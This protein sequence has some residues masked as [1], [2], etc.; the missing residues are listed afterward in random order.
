M[1]SPDNMSNVFSK[2]KLNGKTWRFGW[3]ILSFDEVSTLPFWQCD[4]RRIWSGRTA[5]R[6]SW[7]S[8]GG[9]LQMLLW[10]NSIYCRSGIATN[11]NEDR[12][13]WRY[14]GTSLFFVVY[15]SPW[16][17]SCN[18]LAR[19]SAFKK[20]NSTQKRTVRSP[21]Q[22]GS[23]IL[24]ATLLVYLVTSIWH[25][26]PKETNGSWPIVLQSDAPC[27][28]EVIVWSKERKLH[29]VTQTGWCQPVWRDTLNLVYDTSAEPP[30]SPS[31]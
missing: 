21:C 3:S 10:G 23:R 6:S 11:A 22:R 12:G 15:L 14:A 8:C 20:F 13:W 24:M 18:E 1:Y 19:S 2:R 31:T 29:V 28:S 17:E 5:K 9:G 25:R 27:F 16:M 4:L 26:W 30:F 7:N